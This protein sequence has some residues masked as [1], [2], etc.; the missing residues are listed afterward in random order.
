M[1]DID[2]LHGSTLHFLKWITK[3]LAAAHEALTWTT[4]YN[5]RAL[6][7]TADLSAMASLTTLA[8]TLLIAVFVKLAVKGGW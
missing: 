1:E 8:Y 4:F 7:Q 5:G 2:Q 6:R 3:W